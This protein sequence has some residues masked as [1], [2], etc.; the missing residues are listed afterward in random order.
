MNECTRE[1]CE[2]WNIPLVRRA[3]NHKQ[4]IAQVLIRRLLLLIVARSPYNISPSYVNAASCHHYHCHLF[5]QKIYII[6]KIS[7]ELM[8]MTWRVTCTICVSVP[9]LIATVFVNVR[10][11]LFDPSPAMSPSSLSDTDACEKVGDDGVSLCS[12][13][14]KRLYTHIHII[15]IITMIMSNGINRERICT[16]WASLLLLTLRDINI[17]SEWKYE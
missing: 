14:L 7:G 17:I 8:I 3:W 2:C 13:P 4:L 9:S 15:H 12:P 5:P 1:C 6:A 16:S 11:L 10:C